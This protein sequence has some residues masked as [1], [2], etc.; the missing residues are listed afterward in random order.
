[1]QIQKKQSNSKRNKRILVILAVIVL[2]ILGYGLYAWKAKLP[3]FKDTY[4]PSGTAV[5][6]DRT[7]TEKAQSQKLQDD[8]KAK[9]QNDQ[10]DTPAAPSTD[11]S[12]GKQ[13][14]NVL[15][16]RAGITNGTV[17]AGGVVTNVVESDGQCSYIF[18]NGSNTVTKVSQTMTNPSSTS[19]AVVSFPSSELKASGAWQ[20]YIQYDSSTS[21][22][23][24]NIKEF[25]K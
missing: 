5:N 19:C 16:S 25:T 7:D 23:K 3:P 24:S 1:M 18:T 4:D 14:A 8:P 2:L 20:V 22:G 6:M 9:T 15:L 21:S 17:S 12:T 13:Q 10:T 11:Q